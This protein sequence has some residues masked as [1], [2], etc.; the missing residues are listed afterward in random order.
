MSRSH[1]FVRDLTFQTQDLGKETTIM[2]TFDANIKGLYEESFPVVWKVS[3]FGETG[4]YTTSFL[5]NCPYSVSVTYTNQLA[6]S[7]PQVVNESIVGAETCVDINVGEKTS[8]TKTDDVF[9]F[10]TPEKGATGFLQAMNNTGTTQDFAVGFETPGELMPKP[11]LFFGGVG[12]GG[13]VTAQ[14]TPIL[15]V[16]VTSDYQETAIIRGAI[17]TPAIWKQN[18]AGL[19][20]STTWNLNRDLVTGHYTITQAP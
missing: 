17:D 3:T 16:Y 18:L 1:A 14:F 5:A 9:R 19:A 8:L 20:D 12:D 13:H 6:F 10:S 4:E 2:L 11:A 7:K 15:R